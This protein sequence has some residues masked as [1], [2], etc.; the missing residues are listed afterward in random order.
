MG[1]EYPVQM[2]LGFSDGVRLCA[3]RHST[4]GHSQPL[5]VSADS[6]MQALDPGNRAWRR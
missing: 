3:V 4:E 5:Y 6:A 1:I 2:T